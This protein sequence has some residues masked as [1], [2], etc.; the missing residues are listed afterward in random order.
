MKYIYFPRSNSSP[1][2]TPKYVPLP[3]L[4]VKVLFHNFKKKYNVAWHTVVHHHE[5]VQI[6]L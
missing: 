5:N 2:P 4:E 3:P 1:T 6:T